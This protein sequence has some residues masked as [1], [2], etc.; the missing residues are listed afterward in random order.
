MWSTLLK[1]VLAISKAKANDALDQVED[2]VQMIKLATV[3]LE[4]AI[5]KAT[6]ALAVAMANQKKLER[7]HEQFRLESLGWYQKA[8]AALQAGNEPLAQK[9]LTQKAL[10][11]KK[12]VEYKL[13]AD[14]AARSVA[15]LEEQ[16]DDYKLKL[17]EVKTKQSIFIAKAENAKAQKQIAESLGG[18]NGSALANMEKYENSINQME[19]EA[20]SLSQINSDQT[21]LEKEFKQLENNI[22]IQ[23]DMEKLRLDV[24]QQ[25]T[26]KEQQKIA[27][28]HKKFEELNKSTNTHEVKALPPTPKEDLNKKMDDFFNKK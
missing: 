22:S 3:E 19:A 9:A 16:L 17:Q 18:L 10:S 15:Q 2:P 13:L 24:A 14:H 11:D 12:E 6:K 20:E 21:R 4:Q 5:A 1:R 25:N 28:I 23:S 7:D 8:A 27:D 26:L